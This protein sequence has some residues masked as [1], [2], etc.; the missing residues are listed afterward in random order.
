MNAAMYPILLVEDDPNDVALI[1]RAF[2]NARVA[3]PLQVLGDGEQALAYLRGAD[4]FADRRTYPLPIMLLLD[5]KLPRTSGLE[6]LAWVRGQSDLRRLPVVVLTSSR[7]SSDI[8]RAYDLG[9]NSYLVKPVEFAS[10][11]EMVKAVDLY[12]LIL[13]QKPSVE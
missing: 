6:V 9:V 10:L 5:L 2:R 7:Q 1:Q 13:N 12:W 8:N 11:V 3:N 4:E